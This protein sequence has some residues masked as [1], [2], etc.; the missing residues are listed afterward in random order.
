MAQTTIV[1][2]SVSQAT[3]VEQRQSGG[4]GWLLLIFFGF[5]LFTGGF[6]FIPFLFILLPLLIISSIGSGSDDDDEETPIKVEKVPL[7]TITKEV[8]KETTITP[9]KV[10]SSPVI[11]TVI[12][13]IPPQ[14]RP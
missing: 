2:G 14:F 1:K 8:V 5:F 7:H 9:P 13:I 12:P 10:L 6:R 11:E 4:F 3:I